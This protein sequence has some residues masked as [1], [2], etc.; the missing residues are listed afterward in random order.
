[1]WGIRH[2]SGPSTPPCATLRLSA[3]PLMKPLRKA[4]LD[5]VETTSPDS[6]SIPNATPV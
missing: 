5:L 6:L 1:M 3:L 2:L 4:V